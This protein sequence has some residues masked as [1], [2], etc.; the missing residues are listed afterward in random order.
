MIQIVDSQG[1]VVQGVTLTKPMTIRY[2]YQ[3]WEMSDLNLNPNEVR[4]AWITPLATAEQA[5]QQAP[6]SK[7][8]AT[9]PAGAV[10]FMT[11][12]AKTHTLTAQSTMI[13]GPLDVSGQPEIAAPATPDLFEASGNDGQYSYSYPISVAPGPSGFTP[14]FALTYS[15]QSTNERYDPRAPAGDEGEGF[16]LSLGS[17][18]AAQY[19]AT[20]TGG[21][22]T[23][24]SLNGVDGVSDKLLPIPN[25]AGYYDTQHLSHLL[26]Q[27]ANNCWYVWGLDGMYS[28]FGCTSDSVRKDAT[29]TYEWDLNETLSML[30]QGSPNQAKMIQVTYLQDVNGS[31]TRDAEIKQITYGYATESNGVSFTHIDGTIDFHY[32]MPSVPSGDSSFA[33]PYPTNYN[34]ASAPPSSTT[35]RCDDPAAYQNAADGLIPAPDVMAT[36]S[37]D[38]ITSYVG[39]DS[40]NQPAYQYTFTYRDTPYTT[41]YYAAYSQIQESAA[42]E[43]LLTQITPTVYAQGTAHARKPVVFGS[44]GASQ[45]VYRDPSQQVENKTE[46]YGGQTFWQYLNHYEDL[47]TGTGANISY[48]TAFGNTHGTP[49]VTNSQGQVVDDRFDPLFCSTYS[50]CTGAYLHPEDYSW[51]QQVVTQISALGTDSSGNS[52][53]ATTTYQYALTAVASSNDPVGNCNPITGGGVPA[54][55][56]DCVMDNWVPGY[57]GTQTPDHDGDWQDY[58]HAEFRGFNIVYITHPADTLTADYYFTTE[59]WWKPQSD[60]LDYNGGMLYQEDTYQ[61]NDASPSGLFQETVHYYAGVG[62]VPAGNAYS[63]INTCNGNENPVYNPCLQAELEEKTTSYEQDTKANATNPPWVDTKYT[64]DDLN[65]SQGFTY[66]NGYHN[67]LQEVISSSNAPTITKKWTYAT[68]NQTVSGWVYYN[69][70]KVSHSEIDDSSGHVWACQDTTYDEGAPAGTPTPDEGLVTTVKTYSTCGNTSTAVT[71]YTAYDQFGNVVGTVD[72]LGVANPNLYSSN[73]CTI[74]TVAQVS[75]S[76]TAGRYTNCMS[77]NTG[78][79]ANLP[80]SAANALGQTTSTIYDYTSGDEP[81]STVDLNGQTTSYSESYNGTNEIINTGEPGETGSYTSRQSENS[82]CTTSSTL[83]CYEIDTSSSLYPNAIIRTFYDSQGR[84]VET[85]TSGPTPGDDT[86]AITLYNDQAN[87]VWTSVPFE[88]ADGSGYIDPTGAKDINGNAPA[89]TTAFYDVLGRVIATQD[90]NWGSAQE[91]GLACAGFM[92]GTYTSCTNYWVGN[93]IDDSNT[94]VQAETDDANDHQSSIF[95]DALG[96]TVY[97]QTY[98]GAA[99]GITDEQT[100]TEY[101]ALNKPTSVTVEDWA[102]QT[103]QSVTSVTTTMTYDDQGRLLTE[104]DPDQGTFTYT[105]DP[106]GHVLAATQT[107]GSSSRTLGYN[108]DL[109]GRLG[110]EQTAAPTINATGACSAGKPLV[111][112]TYDKTVLGTQG[113]TDFP[114]GQLT[115]SVATTYYPDGTSATVTEQ[116]QHDQRGRTI[117]TQVQLGLPSSWGNLN[118][119]SYQAAM[120][121]N[122]ADQ[123][124]T[125]STLAGS[126]GYTFADVYDSTN[127]ALQGLSNNGNSTANLATLTYNE[128]GQLGTLTYLNGATSSPTSIASETFDYDANQRPLSLSANWL[129]GSGNSGQILS[130]SRTYDNVGNATNLSTTFAAV[131]GQTGSGGSE[132]QNFCYDE[133]NRLIWAGNNGTQP[134]AGSGTCGSGTLENGLSNASENNAY[135]YTHLGQIWQ[136]PIDGSTNAKPYLYCDSAHPHQVSGIYD[137]GTCSAKQGTVIYT[138]TYDPWGNVSGY[139]LWNSW[140]TAT[141]SYDPLNRLTNWS[142]NTNGVAESEQYVYDA[143]GNRILKRSTDAGNTTLSVYPSID[144]EYDY[145]SVGTLTSQLHYYTLAGHLIGSFDGTNTTFY[146]TDFEG[147]LLLSFSKSAVLGEQIYDPYGSQRYT[148]GTINTAKGYTGQIQDAVTGLDYYNARYYLPDIGMFLSPDNVQGNMQGDDPYT[149]A[150]GNPETLTDPTGQRVC[151]PN[152]IGGCVS[153][154]PPGDCGCGTPAPTQTSGDPTPPPLKPI[155][156]NTPDWHQIG[157]IWVY[158]YAYGEQVI[159]MSILTALQSGQ[160]A[161]DVNGVTMTTH[162]LIAYYLSLLTQEYRKENNIPN[163]TKTVGAG[164]YYITDPHGNI[165]TGGIVGPEV[166]SNDAGDNHAEYKLMQDFAGD[167]GSW[168]PLA[169]GSSVHV[170]MYTEIQPCK[171]R[172]NPQLP[173]W[174]RDLNLVAGRGVNFSFE[175]YS[176]RAQPNPR[177]GGDPT[178]TTTRLWYGYWNSL[179]DGIQEYWPSRD[180]YY[181]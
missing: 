160:D 26:V 42:G 30:P 136:A 76:W 116:S 154:P 142:G 31:T 18:T 92:S 15:S 153:Y 39:V 171:G 113:S 22:A 107:S 23:Y 108:Y 6:Q 95:T 155:L 172:C 178:V 41:T 13:A 106:D 71:S 104:N 51:S 174:A 181:R 37:L 33:T 101:N 122:D 120:L 43:H 166:G 48:Q 72:P 93:A 57:N 157:N 126:A 4:L 49:D 134:G 168:S 94:Y 91:P 96:R 159:T 125:T 147:T 67:L 99:S 74:S 129:S 64:Y 149:Y 16:S 163:G 29:G 77:Y 27:N 151:V 40:A 66:S 85:R 24:Y 12:D 32:H 73:G 162:Q 14:Q 21:A 52:T 112:N 130:Q 176:S 45:D 110:C 87:T 62:N 121:Y 7:T 36:M 28:Q 124:T 80:V 140:K 5:A 86:V 118:L 17:I 54:Q 100:Q 82:T 61:W 139:T 79:T 156:P 75:A 137:G 164:F 9:Q 97:T 3:N 102:A 50:T 111:Q 170:I 105:Y 20:S 123:L 11:N 132:V 179:Y 109:L 148:A 84:A 53:A 83:P 165:I 115:Q 144:E 65:G 138:A 89:G 175:V 152:G 117:D 69:V 103:N 19:P 131:S 119:P 35:L 81:S 128:Y 25:K 141:L 68:D 47:D 88:V 1:N 173:T 133:Q 10:I 158:G 145:S 44:T 146:L 161:W 150:S 2:H 167:I 135:S 90:P 63:G 177:F 46:Q 34:C 55:E 98:S 8:A 60:G 78:Q 127:G 59:G 143:T 180:G 38:S 169:P 114:I 56:A 70:D 58:Y